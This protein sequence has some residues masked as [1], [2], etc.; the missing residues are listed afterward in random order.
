MSKIFIDTNILIYSIDED[1]R[2]YSKSQ[3]ILFD[4]NFDLYTSSKNLSGRK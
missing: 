3:A 1:S 4:S 2:F